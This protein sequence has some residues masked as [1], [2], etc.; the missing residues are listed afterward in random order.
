MSDSSSAS[1]RC[2]VQ[3][4]AAAETRV[5]DSSTPELLRKPSLMLALSF[6]TLAIQGGQ[7]FSMHINR[8]ALSS[9]THLVAR[10]WVE[11]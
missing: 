2:R 9:C 7:T 8:G 10:G 4:C 5:L 11:V 6:A 3:P 1:A